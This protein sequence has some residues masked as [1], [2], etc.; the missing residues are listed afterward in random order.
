[1]KASNFLVYAFLLLILSQL[2]AVDSKANLP[3]NPYF[4]WKKGPPKDLN[5]FPIAVWL[6][7]P[8]N[9]QRYKEAGFN[10]YVGLWKGP[11]E[12]QLEALRK[13][14]M[15]VIC[16][17]NEVGL[18]HLDD[19]I[20]VGWMHQD[21]PDN[22]QE[23]GKDANGNPIYDG[24]VPP[25]EI[26]ERYKRMKERDPDRPVY[27]GLGQ[28][29]ANDTWIGRGSGS[30]PDDYFTYV[31]GCDIVSYDVYPVAGL[32]DE[33][34]LWYV[35]KGVIRLFNWVNWNK[36]TDGEKIVWNCIECTRIGNLEKKPTPHQVRAEVWMSLIH[37]SMGIVYFVHQFKPK[38]VEAA[39]FEDSEMLAEVTAINMQIRELAP[40]LNSPT[41][42][43]LVDVR[44]NNPDVPVHIMVKRYGGSIYIFAVG[45]KNGPTR[46][47]FRIKENKIKG[48]VEVLWEGREIPLT[49]G[50]FED[51]FKPYDVH[52]YKIRLVK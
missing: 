8:K 37:G 36:S 4:R 48:K 45:M 5:F 17:Q 7:D 38:F 16:D 6:Q 29:V 2:F 24:P 19:P 30:H 13:A 21:E 3:A 50:L 18:R 28:G 27:L 33:N 15:M 26:V 44:S 25:K 41:I 35:A 46:A 1:M 10:L 47:I 51:D 52:L 49:D 42:E 22:A 43:D 32:N 39:L 23:I 20:I 9:A 14:G 31:K 12:E 40:V 11:T 34:L